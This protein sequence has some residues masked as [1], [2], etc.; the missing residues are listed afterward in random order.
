MVKCVTH[1][2]F[3]QWEKV[4]VIH[5]VLFSLMTQQCPPQC[6]GSIC[7]NKTKRCSIWSADEVKNNVVVRHHMNGWWVLLRYLWSDL[8]MGLCTPHNPCMPWS[9]G[10]LVPQ[11][12]PPAALPHQNQPGSAPCQTGIEATIPAHC[13]GGGIFSKHGNLLIAMHAS[14][15]RHEGFLGILIWCANL[16]VNSCLS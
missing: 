7:N 1:K 15:G 6:L 5:M 4:G 2:F 12:V 11:N 13:C 3:F 9:S 16:T 10:D 14:A 8:G